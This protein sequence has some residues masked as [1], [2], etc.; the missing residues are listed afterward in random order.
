[1]RLAAGDSI[2]LSRMA[3]LTLLFHISKASLNFTLLSASYKSPTGVLSVASA[4]KK[5]GA[6]LLSFGCRW[7]FFLAAARTRPILLKFIGGVWDLQ[8]SSKAQRTGVKLNPRRD[9]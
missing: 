8:Q 3:K 6:A 4:L 2:M 1:V 7:A 5:V 9:F